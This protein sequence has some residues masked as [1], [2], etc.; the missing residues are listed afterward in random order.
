LDPEEVAQALTEGAI[1]A[2]YQF[3]K[4]IT[5][6]E[7]PRRVERLALLAEDDANLDSIRA[8]IKSG[9][10]IAE[11]VGVSRDL[12]NE[13]GSANTP[14]KM[15]ERARTVAR[16]AGL[17]A[18]ILTPRELEAKGMGGILAVGRGSA[19]PPRLIVLEH[20]A[21]RRGSRRKP[22]VALVGKGITFDTGGISLKPGAE[23]HLMKGDMS[24]GAAVIGA[25]RAVGLLELPLHVVGIVPAAA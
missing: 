4:Y 3:H 15:A 18:K 16:E 22:T 9:T 11:S 12:S 7:A 17:R 20:G 25:M 6:R 10:I 24:G 2:S 5:L 19:N 1:L 21:P 14:M 13:P 8:G 23:M